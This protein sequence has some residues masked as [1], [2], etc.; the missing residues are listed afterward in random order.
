MM[1]EKLTDLCEFFKIRAHANAVDSNPN[2][3][4]EMLDGSR[5]YKV[6]LFRMVD[7]KQRSLTVP[8]SQGPA[9]KDPPTAADVLSC[10]VSDARLGDQS[11]EDFCKELAY[12]SDS[13]RAERTWRACS[14][15]G[16]KVVAFL[17]DEFE[18]FEK[19]EH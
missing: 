1:T 18:R 17:G 11:F 10:L 15:M 4:S 2:M 5:H 8:F 16:S 12:D 14:R 7:G 9:I 6:R 19:A 3:E 13:R